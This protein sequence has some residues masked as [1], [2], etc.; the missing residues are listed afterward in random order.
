MIVLKFGVRSFVKGKE[1][2]LAEMRAASRYYNALVQIEQWRRAEYSRIRSK[3]VPGLSEAEAAYEQ[4]DEAI[5]AYASGPT[6]NRGKIREKRQKETVKRGAPTK[7]VDVQEEVDVIATLKAWRK[8]A[9]ALFKPMRLR[10]EEIV[11]PAQTEHAERVR[12]FL[13]L[14]GKGDGDNHAKRKANIEAREAMLKETRWPETWRELAVLEATADELRGWVKD[15]RHLS[16]GTYYAVQQ[17]DLPAACKRP[18]P[19][20]DGEPVKMRA[21]PMFSPKKLR[22]IGWEIKGCTWDDVLAGKSG[23]L[24]V[25][26]IRVAGGSNGG[27]V[28]QRAIIELRLRAEERPRLA[29]DPDYYRP[30][31]LPGGVWAE[32]DVVIHRPIPGDTKI[33]WAF[34]VPEE[35]ARGRWEYSL[36]FTADPTAP[37]IQ[38]AP[39]TGTCELDLCWTKDPDPDAFGR[40][41]TLIVAKVNGEPLR[42]PVGGK[43]GGVIAALKQSEYLRSVAD[44]YFDQVREEFVKRLPEMPE[45]VRK[46]C[47]SAEQWKSSRRL[48][49]ASRLLLEE[50][51][52]REVELNNWRTWKGYRLETEQDLFELDVKKYSIQYASFSSW[53]ATW[54]RKDEH[55][56]A[57]AT[58]LRN[59]AIGRRRDFYRV[60]AA[61]LSEK[62]EKI[63]VGGAVDLASIALRDKAE[64]KPSELH[65]AARHN[66]Q[67]ACVHELKI[68]LKAAFGPDR[69][70]ERSGEKGSPG[71]SRASENPSTPAEEGGAVNAAE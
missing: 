16:V 56:E 51:N 33:K 36:Q 59:H 8:E 21:R 19:R 69:Y 22:R 54:R 50:M 11:K 48:R 26:S 9:A 14:W 10:F 17:R 42:L 47:A 13:A 31:T 38:R 15:A 32:M 4:L 3:A 70:S 5:G 65:R 44:K 64:D 23:E 6:G 58:G 71:S 60:T 35:V 39:G 24:H 68:A 27:R 34:L 25:K 57:M 41:E 29:G 63:I 28:K 18:K 66:R 62:Y 20:P 45:K 2:A 1:L 43:R 67:L 53:L 12:S 7:K 55:L 46:E 49:Y 61:R 52:L 40:N 30:I 37:L